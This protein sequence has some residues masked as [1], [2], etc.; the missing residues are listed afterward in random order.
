[1]LERADGT[2][3][4]AQIIDSLENVADG[5]KICHQTPTASRRSKLILGTAKLKFHHRIQVET[6]FIQQRPV[7]YIVNKATLF[8][9]A[10]FFR[11]QSTKEISNEMQHMSS[12]ATIGPLDFLLVDQGK[13]YTSKEIREF[14][15]AHGVQ[16]DEAPIET[17]GTIETIGRYH[18]PLE[19]S[20]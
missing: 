6:T 2:K 11:K 18:A 20:C 17:C 9:A 16:L 5:Y 4:E 12:L 10:S 19:L 13:A 8:C 14:L 1:M 3:I 7:L 15:E